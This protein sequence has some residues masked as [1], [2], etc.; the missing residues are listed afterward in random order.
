[1]TVFLS[2]AVEPEDVIS[3]MND[4]GEFIAQMLDGMAEGFHMGLLLD[5]CLDVFRGMSDEMQDKIVAN[6][7]DFVRHM[8][9]EIDNRPEEGTG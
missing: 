9:G 7:E 8:K 3:G 5:N 1:M 6:F 2:V 4:D